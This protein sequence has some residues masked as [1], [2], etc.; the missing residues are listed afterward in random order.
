MRTEKCVKG[1]VELMINGYTEEYGRLIANSCRAEGYNF[2]SYSTPIARFC[3][4][5]F[6]LSKKKYSVTTSKQQNYLRK[7]IPSSML[8]EVETIK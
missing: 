3:G 1:W 7:Y 5:H 6:E 2:I 8:V 4:D